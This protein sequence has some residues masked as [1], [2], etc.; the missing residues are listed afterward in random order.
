MKSENCCLIVE[1]GLDSRV[2]KY[3][4][5]RPCLLSI[6]SFLSSEHSVFITF[7][8]RH[9][10]GEM[11]SGHGCMCLSVPWCIPTTAWTWM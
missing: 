7:C 4:F 3:M 6:L 10:W 8:V 2:G 9:S 5:W 11:Y 1:H